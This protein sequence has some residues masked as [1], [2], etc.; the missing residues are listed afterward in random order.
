M[1]F[2]IEPMLAGLFRPG[3]QLPQN[4]Q[5]GLELPCLG[6]RDSDLHPPKR[7]AK[8]AVIFVQQCPAPA[9]F[10]Q[11][12]HSVAGTPICQAV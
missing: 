6:I 7:F 12:T 5:A 2:G 1:Q 4:F 11:S 8:V 3:D 9:H 10:R